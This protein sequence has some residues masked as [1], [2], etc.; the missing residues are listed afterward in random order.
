MSSRFYY[1]YALQF[2]WS[3]FFIFICAH[4]YHIEIC[5]KEM[6]AFFVPID[7]FARPLFSR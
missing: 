5:E 6:Y 3:F 2:V 1:M 7:R 4:L